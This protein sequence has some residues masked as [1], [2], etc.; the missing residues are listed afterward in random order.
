MIDLP[1]I[2]FS[3]SEN[4]VPIAS[5]GLAWGAGRCWLWFKVD[6]LQTRHRLTVWRQT[7][8]LKRMARQLGETS[9]WVVRDKDWNTSA[10][11][12]KLMGFD[13]VEEVDGQELHVCNLYRDGDE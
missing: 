2:G 5:F 9:V 12:V 8:R 11:L 3:A 7:E 13:F 6:E 1:A 10:K 4:G